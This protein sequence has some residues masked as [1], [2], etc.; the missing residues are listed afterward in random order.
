MKYYRKEIPE[1]AVLIFG[2][3]YRFDFLATEDTSLIHEL[4]K[5][6]AKQ[7]GGVIAITQEEYDSEL[8]KKATEQLL[9][10]S[11]KPPHQRQ[12]IRAPQLPQDRRAVEVVVNPGG[13][14]NGMLARP[15]IG[16]DG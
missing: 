1:Q 6:I 2:H 8:K 7:R 12:E 13:R 16:R 10:D 4:D 9:R 14:L 3:P 5:C 15:Q 11:S